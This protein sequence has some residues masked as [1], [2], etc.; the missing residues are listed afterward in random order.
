MPD[1]E[2]RAGDSREGERREMEDG[3]GG[4]ETRVLHTDL[5]ADSDILRAGEAKQ[6]SE[7]IAER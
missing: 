3:E 7:R 2:H 5:D 4:G 1:R 6:T